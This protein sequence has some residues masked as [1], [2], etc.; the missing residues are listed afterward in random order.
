MHR[1]I[2]NE[3]RIHV[4]RK[5]VIMM[6]VIEEG[7]MQSLVELSRLYMSSFGS[8]V[9]IIVSIRCK[10]MLTDNCPSKFK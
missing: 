4:Y 9:P 2:I 5:A 8:C 7:K 3:V 6:N 1:R 10:S